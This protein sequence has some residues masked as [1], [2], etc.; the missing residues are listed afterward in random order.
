[1]WCLRFTSCDVERG[2][3]TRQTV[4]R[5]YIYDN[6]VQ[7]GTTRNGPDL[8]NIGERQ[9]SAQWHYQHLYNP[10]SLT[11]E[12]IMPSFRFLFEK[13]KIS[14]QKSEDALNLIGDD[15]VEEGYEVVPTQDAKALVGYLLS[16]DHSHPLK[17]VKETKAAAVAPAK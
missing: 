1:M 13:R 7:L 14:G 4:A 15:A 2:W 10:R 3:G 8:A 16:L 9:K 17:E 11:P 12:S 6:P 5:D